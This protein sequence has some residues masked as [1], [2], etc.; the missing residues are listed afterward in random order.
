MPRLGRGRA[1]PS[2]SYALKRGQAWWK[3]LR[4]WR[5]DPLPYASATAIKAVIVFYG[6]APADDIELLPPSEPGQG[7]TVQ[8]P[9]RLLRGD[10]EILLPL[11]S[12]GDA[13][14]FIRGRVD[15]T[16]LQATRLSPAGM[17]DIRGALEYSTPSVGKPLGPRPPAGGR[18]GRR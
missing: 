2:A 18:Q 9:V 11:R 4:D 15:V 17:A 12:L 10:A 6:R 13:A 5:T 8:V 3:P 16:P 14:P 1:A 7:W